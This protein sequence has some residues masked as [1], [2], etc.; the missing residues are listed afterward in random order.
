MN[1][2]WELIISGSGGQGAILAGIIFAEA[3]LADG[4]N[5]IQTQSYGPEARGGASRSEVLI[6][7]EEL[8]YPK[9]QQC[10]L[11][12]ALTQESLD[13]YGPLLADGGTLIIDE[14]IDASAL[15]TSIKVYKA[16]IFTAAAKLLR[17]MVANVLVLGILNT[18][19]GIV[20]MESLVNAVR[21][22]VPAATTDI[23]LAALEEGNKIG[24]AL[25]A[26][27]KDKGG[28]I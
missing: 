16:P 20:S 19:S 18:V 13:K 25:S 24:K 28:Y 21:A 15:N 3:A 26:K 23:N 12:V 14:D 7:K 27:G 1:N 17:P 22:R 2:N 4:Y 8:A 11:M 6:S 5:V 10:N 9:V